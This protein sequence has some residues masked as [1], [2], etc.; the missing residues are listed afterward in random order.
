MSRQFHAIES[1]DE[2][3]KTF[4]TM[5]RHFC[6]NA[7]ERPD[8]P[9]GWQ[10]GST[11]LT[12][13]WLRSLDMWA[14]LEPS[15]PD[16]KRRH[17]RFWNCFG[18]GEPNKS[19]MLNITV[20]MNPPHEGVDRRVAG[21]FVQSDNGQRFIAHTGKVGGGRKGI[22]R[23]EFLRFMGDAN[24]TEVTTSKGIQQALVFG[25][26]DSPELSAQITA[27]IRKVLEFKKQAAK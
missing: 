4:E 6:E 16:G 9:I 18:V 13:Y 8:Q 25:P 17:H 10:G 7:E 1:R 5:K 15:P 27:F 21:L 26:L 23:S 12:S 22:G 3:S 24:W 14:V 2:S 11:R 20:E 19:R